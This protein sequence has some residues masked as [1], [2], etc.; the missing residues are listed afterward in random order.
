MVS[1]MRFAG[2]RSMGVYTL[3][4]AA[5]SQLSNLRK[6]WEGIGRSVPMAC[7]KPCSLDNLLEVEDEDETRVKSAYSITLPA[8]ALSPKIV[9]LV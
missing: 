2:F 7:V 6:R 4:P 8:P 5:F 1:K 9:T 3:M